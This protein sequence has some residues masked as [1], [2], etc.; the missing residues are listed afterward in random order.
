MKNVCCDKVD[1]MKILR[2]MYMWTK[3][4]LLEFWNLGPPA[5]ESESRNVLKD[6]STL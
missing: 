4:R 1:D 5:S 3:K 2:E 6:S